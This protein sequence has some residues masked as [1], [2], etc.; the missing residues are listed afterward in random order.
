M[1]SVNCEETIL[2]KETGFFSDMIVSSSQYN[3]S[4]PPFQA[5]LL[6]TDRVPWCAS[7]SDRSPYV[8]VDIRD[9]Y[10]ICAISTQGNHNENEWV[11]TYQLQS[12]LDGTSWTDYKEG[13]QPR[14]SMTE[15]FFFSVVGISPALFVHLKFIKKI[16][17]SVLLCFFFFFITDFPGEL[18]QYLSR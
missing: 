8:Q 1:V 3:S 4:T 5:S 15:L 17:I 2:G 9:V 18:R 11:E 6:D 12:S 16:Y 7:D 14:V 13:K 10:I